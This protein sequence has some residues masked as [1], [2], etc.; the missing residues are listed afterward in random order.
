[1]ANK[2]KVKKSESALTGTSRGSMVSERSKSYSSVRG[3]SLMEL[4]VVVAMTGIL[5][6]IAVPQMLAQRRLMRSVAVSREIGA[7]LR[8]A[9]QAAM[10]QRRAF[11]FQYDDSA[12]QI[13]IIGPIPPG[14][15]GLVDG[16]YPNNAGSTVV[17]VP[18]AQGGLASDEISYGIPTA[19]P[20]L[21]TGALDD[22]AL[23]TDLF[24]A[25]VNITFQPDG[26]VIDTTGSPVDRALFI[27]NNRAALGTAS[28]ISVLGSSGRVKVWR[29][30]ISGNNYAE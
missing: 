9:R 17:S 26:S 13:K 15:A 7:Q 23:K 22:G 5:S 12:K 14:A 24:N 8:Y 16:A 18:L 4:L 20:A 21:P 19:S 25:K 10:S 27:Y 29:Y 30:S 2:L 28:A 6:V 1:M 11:T 3:F